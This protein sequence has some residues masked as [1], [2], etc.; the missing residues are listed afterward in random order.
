MFTQ[1]CIEANFSFFFLFGFFLLIVNASFILN[2][3]FNADVTETLRT[4]VSRLFIALASSTIIRKAFSG[5]LS[6]ESR[7]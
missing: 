4:F 1:R 7:Q 5:I 2:A 3:R 6:V